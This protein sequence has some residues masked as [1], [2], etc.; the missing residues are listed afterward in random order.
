MIPKIFLYI[1][2]AL[3]VLVGGFF[4]LNSYIYNEKQTPAA[5]DHKDAEYT[6][7]GKQVTLS[8][9]FAEVEAAPGSVSK[10][11]TKYFG[12][13][14]IHDLDSDGREDVI[15]LLTQETG[16]SGIFYY[17]VAALNTERGYVGSEGLLLG[18]RI[19]PQT[20]EISRNPNHKGVIVVNYADRKA[21][22]PMTV[23]P[24]VG[25]SIWLKLDSGTLQFGE[26]VQDF[27][28]EADPSRMTLSMKSWTWIS[29]LYSNGTKVTPRMENAFTVTFSDE[30]K[31][32]ATTDCN[33]VGGS[34][35]AKE[36][37]IS[38]SNMYSTKKYCADAQEEVFTRLLGDSTGYHF[39][40]RG[41]LVLDLKFDSGSVTF[42]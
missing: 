24:S 23:Q 5:A 28:G 26:V 12:N 38:F 15:F 18:D 3:V 21:G 8:D 6:I 22:E 32:S 39:T 9:G 36:G 2:A 34:Y 1:V 14:I 7:D 17:V 37:L 20:T 30:G 42:R 16:G 19:A 41:E 10:I 11:T 13:E 25:K 4:T 27:E 31:F 33:S 35:S 29:A 40:S